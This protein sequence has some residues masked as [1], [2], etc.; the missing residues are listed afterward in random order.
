MTPEISPEQI[1]ELGNGFRSA[2]ILFVASES[3]LFE[4]LAAGPTSL[5]NLSEQTG[6]APARLGFL[7]D[8]LVALG[9]VERQGDTYRNGPL[10][11]AYLSGETELD[12]RP[13]LRFWNRLSWPK[14]TGLEEAL[15][16]GRPPS[17]SGTAE[18]QRIFSEGVE[19]LTAST[20]H[21]LAATYDFRPHRR[22]LDLG[23]GTGSFLRAILR[24]HG[25]LQAT[26]FERPLVAA[27]AR[28]RLAADPATRRAEVVAGD[29]DQD[30]IPPDHDAI[31]VSNVLHGGPTARAVGLLRRI[32]AAAADQGRLLLVD[33]WTG[34]TETSPSFISVYA[35]EFLL[36]GAEAGICGEDAVHGW[37]R[38]SG[39][40]LVASKRLNGLQV[41][42]VAEAVEPHR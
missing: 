12:L 21:A 32:R 37:L 41:L 29:F 42:L 40:R 20:A 38:E 35:G 13:A 2:K 26:L 31:L 5:E 10:A 30:P 28:Q 14:W 27:I 3:G 22:V 11:A 17:R 23:G 6:I 39:W 33:G 15:R 19:A 34:P 18:E 16:T 8:A 9:L 24:R 1:M 25:H 36:W 4:R 7:V